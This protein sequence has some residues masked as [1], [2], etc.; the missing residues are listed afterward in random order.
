M[1]KKKHSKKHQTARHKTIWI[2]LAFLFILAAFSGKDYIPVEPELHENTQLALSILNE[3]EKQLDND[4][5][6]MLDVKGDFPN[7]KEGTFEIRLKLDVHQLAKSYQKIPHY[8]VFFESTVHPTMT[9]RYN[10]YD[11]IIEG[12]L[13]KMKSGPLKFMDGEYHTVQY[14]YHQDRGQAIFFDGEKVI[15]SGFDP[16]SNAIT[17]NAIIERSNFLGFITEDFTTSITQTYIGD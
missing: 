4:G 17:G 11:S 2:T 9:L 13:P 10:V 8:I 7:T 16:I 6:I 5:K 1:P 14:T 15:Q 3:D 12:G